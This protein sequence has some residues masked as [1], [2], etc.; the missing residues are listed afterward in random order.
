[1]PILDGGQIAL[2]PLRRAYVIAAQRSRT[3]QI[4]LPQSTTKYF[5]LFTEG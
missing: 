4:K 2:R 5:S 3:T 1:M